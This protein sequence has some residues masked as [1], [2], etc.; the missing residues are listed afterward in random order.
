[1]G[2][3]I[4]L[5]DLAKATMSLVRKLISGDKINM[6]FFNADRIY[7]VNINTRRPC[8]PGSLT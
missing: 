2:T 7:M 5:W 8:D 4:R 1:M 6:I 3:E